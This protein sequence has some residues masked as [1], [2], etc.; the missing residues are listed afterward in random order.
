MKTRSYIRYLFHSSYLHTHTHTETHKYRHVYTHRS[1]YNSPIVPKGVKRVIIIIHKRRPGLG[2]ADQ[3]HG[4][5]KEGSRGRM[6]MVN[7]RNLEVACRR[8][9]VSRRE[10][11][12]E[13]IEISLSVSLLGVLRGDSAVRKGRIPV[14]SVGWWIWIRF[15]RI[16]FISKVYYPLRVCYSF[17]GGE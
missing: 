3:R 2:F 6:K 17:H 1:G 8:L 12:V 10:Y 15:A 14:G 13:R 5:P 7:R 16:D 4:N 11:R 9:R